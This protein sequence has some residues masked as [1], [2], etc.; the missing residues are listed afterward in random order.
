MACSMLNSVVAKVLM[1]DSCKIL[2]AWMPSH[3]DGILMQIL[4]LGKSGEIIFVSPITP[5]LD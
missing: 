2:H 5:L 3:V 4:V 1:P